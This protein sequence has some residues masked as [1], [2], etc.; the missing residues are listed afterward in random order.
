MQTITIK[1]YSFKELKDEA[2]QKALEKFRDINVDY[3]D[4]SEPVIED[5]KEKL[6]NLGFVNPE[7]EYSGF[8]S[9]GDGACFMAGVDIEKW[10]KSHKLAGKFKALFNASEL[11]NIAVVKTDHH[12]SHENSIGVNVESWGNNEKVQEQ[13][14]AIEGQ[15]KDEARELSRGIYKDLE[16]YFTELTEDEAVIDTI[17]ANDYQFSEFGATSVGL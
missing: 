6:G 11:V 5:W 17:E 8:W 13:I 3:D 1:T 9:Q 7:I 10:L 4:W 2:R 15:I 12:Y 16:A 14:G